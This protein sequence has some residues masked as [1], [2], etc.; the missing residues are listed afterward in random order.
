METSKSMSTTKQ[1]DKSFQYSCR[2]TLKLVDP[3]Y[4]KLGFLPRD[5][6]THLDTKLRSKA[7]S[8]ACSMGN[9]ECKDQA[10]KTFKQWMYADNPDL[11]GANP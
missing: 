1:S 4:Q 3:L 7:I 6:D 11:S 8:W 2:Y 5:T 10:A 9:Q